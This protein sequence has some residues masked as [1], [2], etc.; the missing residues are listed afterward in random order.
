MI[1]KDFDLEQTLE[2][3]QC[4]NFE[5]ISDHEYIVIACGRA[6]HVTQR[7]SEEK[8]SYLNEDSAFKG[9]SE[10]D[11]GDASAK[12][13]DE[14]WIPYFDLDRDYDEIGRELIKAEPRLGPVIRK[15]SGLRILNQ[16][17]VETLLSFIISQNKNIPQIKK[18]VRNVCE[19]FGETYGVDERGISY[20]TFPS[21][22]RLYQMTEENLRE[23]KTGFRAP[24]LMNAIQAV[25]NGLNGGSLR[26]MTYEEAKAELTAIKG[27]GDKVANCVLLFSLGFRSAFPVDVW[28]KR[29]MEDMYFG[30]NT[31]KKV[32]ETFAGEKFGRWGGYAQQYLFMYARE[33][34]TDLK[35]TSESG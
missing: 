13:I 11:F 6:V 3:G 5:K 12:D 26:K 20:K 23:L 35:R 17:F 16:E 31:D 29:I 19:E 2:C 7:C 9:D 32:I 33:Q 14:I 18:I 24:Y 1:V 8:D 30:C 22:E 15:Y 34:K 27:V 28:I 25:K 10:L 21:G 4:F